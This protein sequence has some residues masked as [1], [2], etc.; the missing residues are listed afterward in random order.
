MLG[1]FAMS[2]IM[3]ASGESLWGRSYFQIAAHTSGKFQGAVG[4]RWRYT[5]VRMYLRT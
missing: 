5:W 1:S 3:A 4:V 2:T